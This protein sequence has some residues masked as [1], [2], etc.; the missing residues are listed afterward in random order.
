MRRKLILIT[1][2]LFACALLALAALPW[3]LGAALGVAGKHYGLTFG[4]YR[5]MGYTRFAL[6]RVEVKE[7]AVVVSVSRVELGTPLLWLFGKQGA[8]VI[9]DWSVEV[10]KHAPPPAPKPHGWV[11]L[12]GL[13]GR[14]TGKLD[15][16]LPP[17]TARNG[18]VSWPGSR[19]DFKGA[20]W[21]KNELKVDS[22]SWRELSA[23]VVLKRDVPGDRWLI[24]VRDAA[25]QWDAQGVS[26]GAAVEVKGNWLAQPW[27]VAAEFAPTGWLPLEAQARAEKWALPG[28]RAKL[29]AYYATIDGSAGVVWKNETLSVALTAAGVPLEGKTEV[30]PLQV[31]LYAT[32]ASNRLSIDRLELAVPGI[33]GR[34]SEPIALGR[35][36]QLISGASRFE[37]KADLAQQPWFRGRGLVNGVVTLTPRTG[38]VPVVQATLAS[39]DA[40]VAGWGATKADV[41]VTVEWPE[42][43]VTGAKIELADGDQLAVV[44]NWNADTRT[45]SGGRVSGKISR[46]TA[47]RWL[48]TKMDFDTLSIDVAAQGRWPQLAH[49]GQIEA[50]GLRVSPLRPVSLTADWH[51]TGPAIEQTVIAVTAGTTAVR[52]TGAADAQSVRVDNVVLTRG[53]AEQ[54]RLVQ[55]VTVTLKPAAVVGPF[56]LKGAE[57][58]V[59]GELQLGEKGRVVLKAQGIVSSLWEELLVLKGPGWRIGSLDAR[60][61][62]NHGPATFTLSGAGMLDFNQGRQADLALSAHGDGEGLVLETLSATMQGKP[63]VRATGK[64]PVS[65]WP[66]QD[67]RLRFKDDAPL[68]LDAMTE[69]HAAFWEQI[70]AFT[71]L[72]I[73]EPEVNLKLAGTLKNPTGE[74]RI[75]IAKIAPGAAA[76]AHAMPEIEAI[77]ARLT[78]A[79]GGLALETF[80]AKVAGQEVRA[81]GRLPVKDWAALAANPAALAEA[82]GEARIEIP[83][84]DVAALTRLAPAYLSPTGKLQ[85]DVSLKPGGQL[86]GFIRLKDAATRPLG[87]LGILQSIG[88]EIEF[89]GRTVKLNNVQA[90]TG[91]RLVILTGTVDLPVGKP[92]RLDL[93][94]RGEKLPFVRKAGL[95][96]RGDIDLR[97]VTDAKGVTKISGGTRLSDSLFLM[98]VRALMPTGGPRNAPGRRPPYFAVEMAPFNDWQLDVT[99]DGDKFLR[100]RTP[101]FT[102]VASA[103]FRLSGTLGDPRVTGEAT[104]NQGQVLLPFANFVVRQ[105]SVRI[106]A[107]DPFEPRIALVGTS[108]RYGYDL[109]ME[110]SGTTDKPQITF[111]STPTLESEQVLLMVM[112]GETP[113]NEINYTGRE[114]AT[115]LGTYLGQSL[116]NELGADPSSGEKL[117]IN[118]GERVSEQGRE[119]YG[120]E[121]E[122][123][124][125]WSLVGEY[126]EYDEYNLGVKWRVLREKKPETPA[127]AKK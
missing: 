42:I 36:G 35:D 88:A 52:V 100:L 127:D 101:L 22:L 76:W 96:V 119:T 111:F 95:L 41:A 28:G 39:T 70:A 33:T 120:V 44:G 110:I 122:L 86:Y 23:A 64:L 107:A 89:A 34:L 29:G 83:D 2:S 67:P 65:V 16:W 121:Y 20:T 26:A 126:D 103:H 92:A 55:P 123:S 54:L 94:L 90:S 68:V 14:I 108:R 3:W 84:A 13:L 6:E 59:S 71:G 73:T 10:I 113:Q 109:R 81:S 74:G 48:S 31:S 8:V 61:E 50:H 80:T 75:D 58:A 18:S 21:T 60:A 78:G 97:I 15:T 1:V 79:R 62:W 116:L 124:P 17:A 53:G 37:F 49:G 45:L 98:D 4:E 43:K 72:V 56:E 5:R 93:A 82:D 47:S 30:P 7:P 40:V 114:R 32:G 85:V 38:G 77:H 91:G 24:D 104:I 102:G 27:A 87:P 69:A 106:T 117:S 125:R 118:V 25:D 115:R 99:V 11:L 9:E 12:R 105:G 112:A 57:A 19:L 51:G 46:T 63:V 66:G